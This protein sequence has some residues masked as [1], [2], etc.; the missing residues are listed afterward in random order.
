MW[1]VQVIVAEQ[2]KVTQSK[3]YSLSQERRGQYLKA[4]NIASVTVVTTNKQCH[5]VEP[6][7]VLTTQ[8]SSQVH[9]SVPH[10][11]STSLA[12]KVTP[13]TTKLGLPLQALE[14]IAEKARELLETDGA[15]V[16]A[17]GYTTEAKM[18]KS[19]SGKRP[20][21]VTPKGKGDG[22]VCDDECPQYKSAKLCSLLQWRMTIL[23]ASFLPTLE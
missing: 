22:Y 17:P 12:N 20:H 14:R 2:L 8:E 13:L 11:T 6:E 18:V 1:Q 16:S 5:N 10:P 4:F 19:H 21:L 15:I 23:T 9:V 3:W 7:T